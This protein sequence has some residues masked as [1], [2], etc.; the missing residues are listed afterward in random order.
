MTAANSFFKFSPE[1]FRVTVLPVL[2]EI[3]NYPGSFLHL[4]QPH[5]SFR[6]IDE[7]LGIMPGQILL[8]ALKEIGL[9]EGYDGYY[10]V[11][12]DYSGP[13]TFNI[14]LQDEIKNQTVDS[15]YVPFDKTDQAKHIFCVFCQ[16]ILSPKGDWGIFI[17]R[18]DFLVLGC[19]PEVGEK[20][21]TLLPDIDRSIYRFLELYDL[22]EQK[23]NAH[24]DWLPEL[25]HHLYG[26]K[27]DGLLKKYKFHSV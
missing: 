26:E 25:I 15:W 21:Q 11:F 18:D 3:F 12:I 4:F 23:L 19:T 2:N 22:F 6:I 10:Y 9:S 24:W 20:L 1:E 7:H 17:T 27:Y 8:D 5:L 14:S 13:P 16:A